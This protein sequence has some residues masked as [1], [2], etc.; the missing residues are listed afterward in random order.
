MCFCF[1]GPN[2]TIICEINPIEMYGSVVFIY[3]NP[4]QMAPN[5]GP[6]IVLA[7][8]QWIV[9]ADR[10]VLDSTIEIVTLFL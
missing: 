4:Q 5:E 10:L 3:T 6:V 7:L 2:K 9:I 1:S 8:D